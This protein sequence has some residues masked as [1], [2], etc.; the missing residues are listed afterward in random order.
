M[1]GCI[2]AANHAL[3]AAASIFVECDGSDLDTEHFDEGEEGGRVTRYVWFAR[4]RI[5]ECFPIEFYFTIA[6]PGVSALVK[7]YIR[8]FIE[9]GIFEL[10]RTYSFLDENVVCDKV[11]I[12]IAGS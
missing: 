10:F 9:I 12:T 6:N 4:L 5:V 11:V 1:V 7:Y 8:T 2:H 3:L